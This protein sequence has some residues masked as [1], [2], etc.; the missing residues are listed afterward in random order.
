MTKIELGVILLALANAFVEGV[1]AG[2]EDY[3]QA[4]RSLMVSII[5]IFIW[6]G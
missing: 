5:F 4:F 1:F 6:F 2:K 3:A